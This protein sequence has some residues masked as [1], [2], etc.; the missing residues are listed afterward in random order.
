[1]A[2]AHP[3]K[4]TGVLLIISPLIS[5]KVPPCS[6]H[7]AG[8]PVFRASI[9]VVL[10]ASSFLMTPLSILIPLVCVAA[11]WMIAELG[12]CEYKKHRSHGE[13]RSGRASVLDCVTHCSLNIFLSGKEMQDPLLP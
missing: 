4:L 10:L 6:L 8:I 1:M 12:W 9:T 11:L 13:S 5:T 3:L 2:A 7:D